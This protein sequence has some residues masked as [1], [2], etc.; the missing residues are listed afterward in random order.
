MSR[1][2]SSL[3]QAGSPMLPSQRPRRSPAALAL[4]VLPLALTAACVED[5]AEPWQLDHDRVI[6]VRASSPGLAPGQRAVIDALLAHRGAPT[7]VAAPTT[8]EVASPEALAD[9]LTFDGAAW[10]VTAPEPARLAAARVA[11]GLPADAPVTLTLRVTFGDALP[12]TKTLLLGAAA[13]NPPLGPMTVDGTPV[14]SG[15]GADPV[16]TLALPTG[17]D[18]PLA[19][20]ADPPSAEQRGD[21]IAWLVSTGTLHDFDLP[22]AFLRLEP[23]D[24]P[25]GELV[26]VR[27]D[28][29]G[30]VTWRSWAFRAEAPAPP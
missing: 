24:A 16:A 7:S 22:K 6:A 20:P 5:L 12:A 3:S 21:E 25:D 18:V 29:R 27:R 14:D 26:V 4:A 28:P 9:V 15:A 10:S 8:A 23:D 13:E 2:P 1:L 19:V 11:L 17:V 30:G